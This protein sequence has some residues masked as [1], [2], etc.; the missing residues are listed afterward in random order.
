M[1]IEKLRQL[2]SQL[3]STSYVLFDGGHTI[4][5]GMVTGVIDEVSHMIKCWEAEGLE[6]SVEEV[7]N[8]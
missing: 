6:V 1:N 4:A 2:R 5:C 7:E 3:E 8:D